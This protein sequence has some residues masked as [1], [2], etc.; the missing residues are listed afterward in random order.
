MISGLHTQDMATSKHGRGRVLLLN[1]CL[2]VEDGLA[3]SHQGKG[4]GAI[5][6]RCHCGAEPR[7]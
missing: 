3:A 6:R 2:T 7:A 4:L 1:A 5:Y